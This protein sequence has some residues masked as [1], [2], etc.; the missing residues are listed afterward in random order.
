MK[1]LFLALGISALSIVQIL[2]QPVPVASWNFEISNEAS[3]TNEVVASIL[4]LTDSLDQRSINSGTCNSQM[5][6]GANWT[7]SSSVNLFQ[8]YEFTITPNAGNFLDIA[9]IVFNYHRSTHGPQTGQVRSSL[10]NFTSVLA[11]FNI[12]ISNNFCL[13]ETIDLAGISGAPFSALTTPVTFR[14][15]GYHSLP[16]QTRILKLD[17][18]VVNGLIYPGA[19]LPVKLTDFS[20]TAVSTGVDLKWTTA[21]EINNDRFV[22]QR[23]ANGVEF[24]EIGVIQGNGTTQKNS[25]YSFTDEKPL[26]GLGYYRL[27]QFDYNGEFSHSHVVSV[28][29]QADLNFTFISG[30]TGGQ[31]NVILESAIS[32]EVLISIYDI[33][34][35]TIESYKLPV[36]KGVNTYQLITD[37]LSA[38]TYLIRAQAENAIY[39]G[40]FIQY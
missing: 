40:K 38:G 16:N 5:Y 29:S 12:S 35:R 4:V 17:N 28:H 32:D 2:A 21:S 11:T 18:V 13:S 37:K 25:F 15:Y 10:D 14:I 3:Y 39:S 19:T 22:I 1:K 26:K 6:Q 7:T 30:S 23:S 33:S 24:E 36:L 31:L 8:Y 34:G 9:T 27:Q 20:A